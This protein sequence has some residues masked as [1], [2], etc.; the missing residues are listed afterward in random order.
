MMAFNAWRE[1]LGGDRIQTA[2]EAQLQY[3]SCT[4]GLSRI[5]AGALRPRSTAEVIQI[6]GIARDHSIPLYPISTGHNWGYGTANPHTDG[7]VVLDLSG[8]A[9]ISDFDA[10]LGL[11]TLEPGVTQAVLR[12]YLD[13]NGPHFMVPTTG[14]G[15]DC[16]ILANAL[17]RGYGITPY[18]DHFGAVTAL[19]A[20]LADGTLY[21]SA[22]TELG[23][24]AID[25]AF[26]WGVGPY[27][28]GLFAQGN[29][30]IV[31][32]MTVALARRPERIQMFLF[33]VAAEAGLEGAVVAIQR[34]IRAVGGTLGSINLMNN[35]RMLA[36]TVPYP[37][38][39]VASNGIMPPE[40]LAELANRHKVPA[41][42]GVGALY[43]S[44][45]M[46]SAAQKIIKRI[47]KPVSNRVLFLTPE[48][49]ARLNRILGSIPVLRRSGLA[50]RM[51]TL[52]KS[53]RLL[54]G[55][56]SDVALP[57]A[58]WRSTA[59]PPKGPLNPARDGCGLI[60]Y[61]PLVPMK[62]NDV[63]RYVDFVG[64]ICVAHGIEPLITLTTLSDRCFDS[65][66]PILFDRADVAQRARATACYDA[67]F[68]VGKRHGF[69]PYRLG[70]QAMD[71]VAA[72]D[73]PFWNLVRSIKSAID[74]HQIIAPARYAPPPRGLFSKLGNETDATA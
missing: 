56:P 14:A 42:T 21:R 65:S 27:L 52:D 45:T 22:L 63:R 24:Q 53:L 68:E 50:R 71:R 31:T 17:E 33:G 46:V 4:T 62:A 70:L 60:W 55:S 67:L 34:I 74:P 1:C 8:M 38:E 47:L 3:G 36:M 58:Y 61:P 28:D 64:D 37:L 19:E 25:R 35:R 30:G 11:V 54:A 49:G 66:V 43:G 51:V 29:L 16:S 72:S 6:V 13:R 69:L 39:R 41:W 2:A 5:I 73:T 32:Q 9:R 23:G 20:V 15:P 7:C 12:D 59:R 18:A 57:L 10:E 26:K 40:V 48:S 44:R